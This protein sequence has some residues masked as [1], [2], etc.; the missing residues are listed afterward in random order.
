MC[1]IVRLFAVAAG[2]VIGGELD[3][4]TFVSSLEALKLKLK[5]WR[6][7][8]GLYVFSKSFSVRKVFSSSPMM[9]SL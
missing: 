1:D 8:I 2:S 6:C 5:L 4:L 3:K 9:V 7:I